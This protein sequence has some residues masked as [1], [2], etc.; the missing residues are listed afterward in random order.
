[1]AALPD[2]RGASTV[3]DT[4]AAL[5]GVGSTRGC[6]LGALR[7]AAGEPQPFRGEPLRLLLLRSAAHWAAGD[8][9]PR[10]A[11]EAAIPDPEQQHQA[12]R[13]SPSWLRDCC[14]TVAS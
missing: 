12:D 2:H 4:C 5:G 3:K 14:R 10:A 9:Q 11:V 6:I 13:V 7:A 1:M 8:P